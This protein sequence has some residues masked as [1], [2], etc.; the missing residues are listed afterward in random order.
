MAY[1]FQKFPIIFTL[2]TVLKLW[3]AETDTDGGSKVQELKRDTKR[4]R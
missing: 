3:L 1:C 4:E 2:Q